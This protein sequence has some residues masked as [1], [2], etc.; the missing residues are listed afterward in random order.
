MDRISD[1]TATEDRKFREASGELSAT[2][3][4]AL[5]LN[6]MQEEIASFIENEGIELSGADLTQL[7]QALDRRF[8][9]W[10]D[11]VTQAPNV[12]ELRALTGMND[13]QKFDNSGYGEN[14]SFT[15]RSGDYSDFIDGVDVIAP[16]SDSTGESG[17]FIADRPE[18]SLVTNQASLLDK[19]KSVTATSGHYLVGRSA[20]QLGIGNSQSDAEGVEFQFKL[21]DDGML[22]M[23]GGIAAPVQFSGVSTDAQNLVG[24]FVTSGTNS[25]GNYAQDPGD[26]FDLDFE[27][28]GLI[29]HHFAD[30][31]GGVWDVVIDGAPAIQVSTWAASNGVASSTV[32][33]GLTEGAHTCT[34]T[35]AGDDPAN[36]PSSGAG[37]SRGWFILPNA[38]GFHTGT[39]IYESVPKVIEATGSN[40]R[41]VIS[42]SSIPE[43][44]I[45]ATPDGSG[46]AGEWVPQHGAGG[47]GACRNVTRDI[48]VDGVSIGSDI[49]LISEISQSVSRVTIVQ[50]YTA[51]NANDVAGDFPMW[52]GVISHDYKDGVLSVNHVFKT[53]GQFYSA[54][55]Y[56][57]MFPTDTRYVDQ[58][59]NGAGY[60]KSVS[61]VDLDTNVPFSL[62]AAFVDSGS[63]SAAV[64][65]SDL[66]A[67]VETGKPLVPGEIFLQERISSFVGKFYLRSFN[68]EDIPAGRKFSSR[69]RYFLMASNGF[70]DIL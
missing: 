22:L 6:G 51:Y 19:A 25:T 9:R 8:P 40:R 26:T 57:N 24:N 56:L 15:F 49:S 2:R 33:T 34:F 27:G 23:R 17:A 20:T 38:T 63:G 55:G 47:V 61:A 31:R 54:T 68:G 12:T 35:F 43:F 32:V 58:Y 5:W 21:D 62:T 59:R 18:P 48:L 28:T 52:D 45:N 4:R 16:D 13:G 3:L 14:N 1:P 29:F 36:P 66:P 60:T 67:G 7:R 46:L 53:G 44:A 65:D 69:A 42:P 64:F 10:R 39:G 30:D 37:N 50:S 41:S 11:A 70:A